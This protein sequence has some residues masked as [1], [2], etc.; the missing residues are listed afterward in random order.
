MP[1]LALIVDDEPMAR[2][3][4]RYFLAEAG[5]IEVVGEAGDGTAAVRLIET[6]P[7]DL[8]FLDVQMP[9]FDGLDVVEAVGASRMP[10]VIFVTAYDKYALKAFEVH[11]LD[12]LL[13][14]FSR[15]RFEEALDHARRYLAMAKMDREF[16][17]KI[18][19]LLQDIQE[20]EPHT[21]RFFIQSR[22]KA[23][24]LKAEEVEWAEAAGNYVLLHVGKDEHILR[25]TLGELEKKVDP[26]AF[27]RVNRSSIISLEA[28]REIQPHFHGEYVLILK[29]GDRVT[30]TRFF[31][32]RFRKAI[33]P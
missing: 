11:A 17:S 21:R 10:L 6:T 24:F 26:R 7:V 32:D 16:R 30:V 15:A 22:G 28:V 29:N 8:V 5:D 27:V 3:V 20:A 33:G 19:S 12:Y 2:T 18:K 23:R 31:R 4:I 25:Q 1:I 13:K 9:E 14:P